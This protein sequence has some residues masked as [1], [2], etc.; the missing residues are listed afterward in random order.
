ML[1]QAMPIKNIP[2][3]M[4]VTCYYTTSFSYQARVAL[5]LSARRLQVY[6]QEGQA[7]CC[8]KGLISAGRPEAPQ[9]NRL[10]FAEKSPLRF[11]E[12]L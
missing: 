12:A 11:R 8:R 4:K 10:G 2:C 6:D 3:L 1:S 5:R 9:D 7:I